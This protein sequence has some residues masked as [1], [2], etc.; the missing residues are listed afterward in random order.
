MMDAARLLSALL[1]V[2]AAAPWAPAARGE[3]FTALVHMEG[4]LELEQELLSGLS[5]YIAA[6]KRR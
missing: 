4:L 3:M 1:L 5:E 6:E 2:T